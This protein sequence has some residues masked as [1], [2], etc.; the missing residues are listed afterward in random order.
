MYGVN[1]ISGIDV[2][3]RFAFFLSYCCAFFF[4]FFFFFKYLQV[5]V[6]YSFPKNS[7]S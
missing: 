6:S 3:N 7:H 4:F 2:S 1:K 5:Y